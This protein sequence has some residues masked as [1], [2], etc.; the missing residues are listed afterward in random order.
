MPAE[1]IVTLAR[2]VPH[3]RPNL[4]LW[5][6]VRWRWHGFTTS[7]IAHVCFRIESDIKYVTD[8]AGQRH[9]QMRRLTGAGH[10]TSA[11]QRTAARQAAILGQSSPCTGCAHD[12]I[13]PAR[14]R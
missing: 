10:A 8:G 1:Q 9:Q 3:S 13:N 12:S 7:G 4:R 11:V 14:M 6:Y 5:N 2:D